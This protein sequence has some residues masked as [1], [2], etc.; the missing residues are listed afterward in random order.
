MTDNQSAAVDAA[1]SAAWS[2]YR[3][4]RDATHAAAADLP[5]V[6][7]YGAWGL[8]CQTLLHVCFTIDHARTMAAHDA[9]A[10]AEAPAANEAT[11]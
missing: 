1:W 4:M 5:N 8:A 9:C 2:A 3:T 10:R 7:T 11:P 6:A